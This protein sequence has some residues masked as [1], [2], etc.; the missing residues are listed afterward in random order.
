MYSLCK[1]ALYTS[2]LIPSFLVTYLD[3]GSTLVIWAFSERD[4]ISERTLAIVVGFD[5]IPIAIIAIRILMF[6]VSI[7]FDNDFINVI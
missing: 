1:V 2:W 3:K 4:M 6:L 5:L 7:V